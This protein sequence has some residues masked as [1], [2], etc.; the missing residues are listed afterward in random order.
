METKFLHMNDVK[1]DVQKRLDNLEEHDYKWLYCYFNGFDEWPL[2]V[3][4]S[5]KLEGDE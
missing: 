2:I 4:K 1:K 3:P 5:V